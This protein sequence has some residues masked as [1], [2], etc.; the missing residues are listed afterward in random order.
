[1]YPPLL[2]S[3]SMSTSVSWNVA[4]GW[5]GTT[6]TKS[7]TS[8]FFIFSGKDCVSAFA[9]SSATFRAPSMNPSKVVAFNAFTVPGL[10]TTNVV[11]ATSVGAFFKTSNSRLTSFRNSS[12]VL[13]SL[14][15]N[16]V[17]GNAA[18]ANGHRFSPMTML[19]SHWRVSSSTCSMEALLV[20]TSVSF[21]FSCLVAATV[22]VFSLLRNRTSAVREAVHDFDFGISPKY[23]DCLPVHRVARPGCDALCAP[24]PR[25][26]E[27]AWHDISSETAN[28]HRASGC[29]ESKVCCLEKSEIEKITKHFSLFTDDALYQLITPRAHEPCPSRG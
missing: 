20:A 21:P 16:F 14:T 17:P 9:S 27:H 25:G 19:S 7:P 10:N 8:L 1:M 28:P 4:D 5:N 29:A 26:A 3:S 23:G 24:T 11:F 15:K 22:W 13:L 2:C 6:S 18:L 12:N